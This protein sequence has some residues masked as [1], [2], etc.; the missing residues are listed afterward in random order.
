MACDTLFEIRQAVFGRETVPIGACTMSLP[1]TVA[2]VLHKHVVLTVESLD[3]MY[4]K[5][6]QPRLQVEKGIAYFFRYHRGEAFATAKVMAEM[7]SS[8]SVRTS[9]TTADCA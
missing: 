5:I 9:P 7:T 4:L 8:S 3:R 2:D 1:A 6:M